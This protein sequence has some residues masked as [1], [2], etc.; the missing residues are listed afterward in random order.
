[1]NDIWRVSH[2]YPCCGSTI[3]RYGSRWAIVGEYLVGSEFSPSFDGVWLAK[4]TLS[5]SMVF[6]EKKSERAKTFTFCL[7][8][9]PPNLLEFY[10]YIF[11]GQI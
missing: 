8:G 9:K 2:P 5:L 6:N 7:G 1:M 11:E 4:S 10:V 3:M